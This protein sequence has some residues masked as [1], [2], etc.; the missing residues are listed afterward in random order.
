MTETITVLHAPGRRLAKLVHSDGH[1][2]AYD[3]S[4]TMNAYTM[5]LADLATLLALLHRVLRNPECCAIRGEVLAG[6]RAYRIRRLLH[7]DTETG[8]LPTLQDVPRRWLALDM[9]G[10]ALPPD[11][12]AADL[13]GCA[14]IALATLPPIFHDAACIVQASASHGFRPDLRLRLWV[15]LSRPAWGHELK[16]WLR[17]TPADPSVFGAAQ[18]IFTAA[19]VF[20]PGMADPLPTRLLSLPGHDLVPVP[21]PEMLAPPTRRPAPAI[22]L[23]PMPL[24]R[25]ARAVLESAAGRI[26]TA[27]KR[28]PVIVSEARNLA[29]F[30]RA[31]WIAEGY[32]RAVLT[33]AAEHAGK[34]DLREIARCIDWGLNHP[35]DAP[36][37]EVWT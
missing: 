27:G 11:V 13:A 20:V 10:V 26:I 21:P 25:Y 28:H 16:R 30:V 34:T 24:A 31:G 5:P 18:P 19:P 23:H 17:D 2:D 7:P 32:V 37:P 1:A 6:E 9:E 29:R 15:W 33:R 8:D 4:K 3:Q 12:P 14:R 22:R 36:L 35:S